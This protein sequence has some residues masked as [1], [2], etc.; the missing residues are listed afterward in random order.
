[1]VD[2]DW[3]SEERLAYHIHLLLSSDRTFLFTFGKQGVHPP[4]GIVA[5]RVRTESGGKYRTQRFPI[6]NW[7]LN[8]SPSERYPKA[9]A[10]CGSSAQTRLA[11]F[12]KQ[13]TPIT[14]PLVFP[15][16]PDRTHV[17]HSISHIPRT[18]N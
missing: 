9:P 4:W 11:Y 8:Q 3:G 5:E 15:P 18:D 2:S 14:T 6:L 17:P 10:Q 16:S 13:S 1:M 7:Q 12:S